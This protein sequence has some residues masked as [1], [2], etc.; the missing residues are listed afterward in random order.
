MALTADMFPRHACGLYLEHNPHRDYY[1][2]LEAYCDE[3]DLTFPSDAEKRQAIEANDLWVLHW[4]P[5][6]PVSFHRVAA[7]SIDAVLAFAKSASDGR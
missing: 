3:Y 7:A 2:T 1:L 4:H 5:D 6:T